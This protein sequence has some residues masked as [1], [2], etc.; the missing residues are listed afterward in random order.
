[1]AKRNKPWKTAIVQ[2]LKESGVAMSRTE[3]AEAIVSKGLREDVGS[4][5]ANTVVANIS[6]SI[7]KD[8]S[9]S[10]F[11][12]VNRGEYALRELI[13]ANISQSIMA[14]ENIAENTDTINAFGMFWSRDLVLWKNNPQMLGQQQLGAIP[15]DMS[16]Q[17][18]V[19]LLYDGR[20]VIYV[21]R[22]I[23]RPIGQRL[24][25][26]TQ[27]R[28]RAR[29]DRFSWFGLHEVTEKGELKINTLAVNT[30]TFIAMLEAVLIESMEPPQN[31]KRGDDFS[32]IEFI[33]TEDPEIEKKRKLSI[34]EQMQS[35]LLDG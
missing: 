23:E 29:W 31:R 2:V 24:Y 26:H 30:E 18:G 21:G 17:I 1:M 35:K 34:L 7:N 28:L 14:D 9:K 10:P 6:T 12:R 20:K 16:Q 33:Q 19:Y 8:G 13:D 27:D 11:F 5:P 3:I 22:S 25:E 15:V 4:T 32:G